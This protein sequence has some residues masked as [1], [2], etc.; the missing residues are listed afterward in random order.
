MNIN[1]NSALLLKKLKKEP[2]NKQDQEEIPKKEVSGVKKYFP[3]PKN[4][5]D[6]LNESDI[7]DPE[8]KDVNPTGN[9]DY[10]ENLRDVDE[11]S[12]HKNKEKKNFFEEV[13]EVDNK[14]EETKLQKEK[15]KEQKQ[16]EENLVKE[17]IDEELDN[18]SP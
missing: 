10:L 14:F 16:Q 1:L 2:N 12:P 6:E 17:K 13:A 5:E 3:K 9:N 4:F 15:V 8:I 18:E 7:N 11:M